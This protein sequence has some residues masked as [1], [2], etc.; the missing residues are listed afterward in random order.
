[1]EN[2]RVTIHRI[3]GFLGK[4]SRDKELDA[5][6]RAHLEML[7]EENI[8][9]GM[10]PVEA[11]EAARREFGGVEQT[12]EL[13]REQRSIQLLDALLQDLRFAFRGL[14]KRPGFAM[15]AILTLAL[16]IG[17]SAAVFSVVDRILFRS[18][19]YPHDD[20]LV[21]F[22]DK[23]PFEAIEFVLGPD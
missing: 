13:H 18:L 23:A 10:S 21:S 1:M 7:A 9:R 16:G 6:L 8:R 12:K 17:S 15:V 5:E 19:P 20:R 4:R 22:G 2:W 3:R 11:R 14:G